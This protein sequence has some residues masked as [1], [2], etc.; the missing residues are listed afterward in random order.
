MKIKYSTTRET[1]V[2]LKELASNCGSS[3]ESLGALASLGNRL[4]KNRALPVEEFMTGI[5]H[6]D[7]A[8]PEAVILSFRCGRNVRKK[9]IAKF[10]ATIAVEKI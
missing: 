9:T 2:F 8:T 4:I 7:E 5:C 3:I 6:V 1:A 10:G